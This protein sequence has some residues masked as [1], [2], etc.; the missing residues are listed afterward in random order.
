[1]Y[2]TIGIIGFVFVVIFNVMAFVVFVQ[3]LLKTLSQKMEACNYSFDYYRILLK[4]LFAPVFLF[5]VSLCLKRFISVWVH[6]SL[7]R[8]QNG[9]EMNQPPQAPHHRHGCNRYQSMDNA[10]VDNVH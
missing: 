1:M 3:V 6:W 9:E 4:S 2:Y 5:I 7:G 8:V 10:V